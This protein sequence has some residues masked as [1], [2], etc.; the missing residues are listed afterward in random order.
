ML[1]KIKFILS[2]SLLTAILGLLGCDSSNG[3]D[4]PQ[5]PPVT[6]TTTPTPEPCPCPQPLVTIIESGGFKLEPGAIAGST[7]ATIFVTN[8]LG[9]PID[10][11]E[12][13]TGQIPLLYDLKVPRPL[14]L[15]ILYKSSTGAVLG[16][17]CLMVDDSGGNGITLPDVDVVM[18]VT[19]TPA[20]DCPS[21]T[22]TQVS[23]TGTGQISFAWDTN[24]VFELR[25]NQSGAA[26]KKIRLKTE[27]SPGDQPGVTRVY[28]V[29]GYGCLSN[30]ALQ[31]PPVSNGS[32]NTKILKVT[33]AS[34]GDCTITGKDNNVSGNTRLIKVDVP[35]GW[36]LTVWK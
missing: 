25:F 16:E 1:N 4:Q 30:L 8:A 24:D 27:D 28:N 2:L 15:K 5:T 7:T 32:V 33:V 35:S 22:N 10:T 9:S 6:T 26:E 23:T 29:N 3:N 12:V 34:T 31:N 17:S 14:K 20:P 36:T 11:L 18:G 19:A 21:L 13:A